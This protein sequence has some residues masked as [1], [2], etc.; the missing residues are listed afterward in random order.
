MDTLDRIVNSLSKEELRFFKLFV[1]RQQGPDERKDIMLLDLMR[2][3]NS[4]TKVDKVFRKLYPH[5]DK[6]AYYRLRNRLVEDI[7][8]SLAIQH[9]D[10]SDYLHMLHFLQLVKIYEAK[11][12]F[13]L[14]IVFL[15]KAE[16]RAI[17]LEQHE[18]LDS[19]YSEFI[20]LS[21]E[22][23]EIDPATYIQKRA[24]NNSALQTLRQIEDTLAIVSHR[25]KLS[26]NFGISGQSFG[27]ALEELIDKYTQDPTLK[28]SPRFRFRL[29]ALVSQLLLQNKDFK[30]L[31]D[32]L[33]KTYAE[34]S[35]EHLFHKDNH[36]T[37]LQ[38]LTYIV[39]SL[40]KNGK[41]SE[42]LRYAE[43]L[44][45]Q[46]LQFNQLH[47]D[48]YA[49]FYYNALVNNY[50]TFDIPKAIDLLNQ[51]L[52]DKLL[53]KNPYYEIF[54]YLNLAT[55]YFDLK[56]YNL[57]IRNLSKLYLLDN[58][59]KTDRRLQFKI[60]M[61]ELIIRYELG[62]FDF[63]HYRIDQISKSYA[64]LFQDDGGQREKL[65][66]S[67]IVKSITLPNGFYSIELMEDVNHFLHDSEEDEQED[68]II[69][70]NTWLNEKTRTLS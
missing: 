30:K 28:Q 56:K 29:Y 66:I 24:D 3:Q 11:S 12:K 54:I 47:Y 48:R 27:I 64:D 62:D 20:R 57:A 39:N 42:S 32:Y 49:I 2:K 18:I 45:G 43:I 36:E 51:L 5:G 41:T 50:S 6:N 59:K 13:D 33:L 21:H 69:R 67:L 9:Y 25:L 15:Q 70:Y 1:Q 68:E 23:I 22:L 58:Y 38:M 52:E 63:L 17:K 44:H 14:S 31:E 34:F 46:M 35:A 16:Q 61:A 4:D 19:I 26:Q 53:N 55:A 65:F 60:S 40:F 37:H 10:D 7:N 8:R